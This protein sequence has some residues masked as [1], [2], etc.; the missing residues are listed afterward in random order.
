[1]CRD[2]KDPHCNAPC[3]PKNLTREISLGLGECSPVRIFQSFF[4]LDVEL[5]CYC[6]WVG[7]TYL[8]ITLQ[9]VLLVDIDV[10]VARRQK[11]EGD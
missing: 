11:V 10:G 7:L 2:E 3:L 6:D 8:W 1:M 9:K 4:V 5:D